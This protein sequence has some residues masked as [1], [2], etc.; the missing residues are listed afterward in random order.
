MPIRL[1]KNLLICI[2]TILLFQGCQPFTPPPRHLENQILPGNS[3]APHLN[4]SPRNLKWWEQFNT[5]ELNRLIETALTDN[6]SIRQAWARL[7]K[8]RA[9]TAAGKSALFPSI[10]L[11]GSYTR[12]QTEKDAGSYNRFSTGPWAS[13]EVDLWGK[14]KADIAASKFETHASRYDLETAAMSVAAQ[15]ADTWVELIATRKQLSLAKQQ[16]S[17][18]TTVL[19]LL[20]L[21][22]ENSMSTALDILQQR[23]VVARAQATVPPI[24]NQLT[25]LSNALA[26]L[27]GKTPDQCP[28]VQADLPEQ[29]PALPVKGVPANLLALR[30]DVRAADSRLT[31]A[32]WN[33]THARTKRLPDLSLTGNFLFQDRTLDLL[34]QNWVLSLGATLGATLFDGGKK[35][36]AVAQAAAIVKERL[37]LYEQTVT[38]AI[39]EVENSLAAEH[40]QRRYVDLLLAELVSARQAKEEA[41]RRYIKGLD[42]FIPFLTEQ[43]NVQKLE[44]R[45]IEQKAALIKNRIAL[46]RAL[47][48]TW[49][50]NM[51]TP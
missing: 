19:D 31:A 9:A 32:D 49:T 42:P 16:L 39:V 5:T 17:L 10:T 29:L 43:V 24:E 41:E 27:L 11:N 26:L 21:R 36:A 33:T 34:L 47:G 25:A 45:L 28:A 2:T 35:D 12:T 23:E 7:E 40:H 46:Y 38:T 15:V 22:F 1:I 44:S 20:E 13:Y 30:P 37:A 48:G 6:F 14:I 3:T 8:A 50:R 51:E 4:T 18:N